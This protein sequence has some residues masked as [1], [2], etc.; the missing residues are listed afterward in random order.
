MS[1][2]SFQLCSTTAFVTGTYVGSVAA[3]ALVLI[4]TCVE[5]LS[6][7]GAALSQCAEAIPF[8]VKSYVTLK[9]LFSLLVHI[10]RSIVPSS[11]PDFGG[12][13][14]GIKMQQFATR[15]AV[16]WH[17]RFIYKQERKRLAKL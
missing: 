3:I 10:A 6:A 9:I 2:F 4:Y 13:T 17:V 7:A 14:W 8:H 16:S 12:Q 5:A 15:H 11:R 1:N